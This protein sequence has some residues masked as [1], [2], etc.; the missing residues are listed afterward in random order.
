MKQKYKKIKGWAYNKVYPHI[1]RNRRRYWYIIIMSLLTTY[2]IR[3]WAYAIEFTPFSDFNGIN[4]LFV[5][6]IIIGLLP[7]F[8]KIEIPGFKM[9]KPSDIKLN[10]EK[11][12]DKANAQNLPM[13]AF[14]GDD[15][16]K[17][18]KK[19]GEIKEVQENSDAT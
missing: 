6:W 7:L 14:S 8:D 13:K 10:F 17:I 1:E 18:K 19:L 3:N 5:V 11:A 9:Q 2:V 16:S 12:A 15:V 4:L